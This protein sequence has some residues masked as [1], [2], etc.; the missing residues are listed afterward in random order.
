MTVDR[1]IIED[2]V[3]VNVIVIDEAAEVHDGKTL[4]ELPH[5]VGIGWLHDG[6]EFTRPDIEPESD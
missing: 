6:E 2:G 5:G 4:F 3:V 1:A